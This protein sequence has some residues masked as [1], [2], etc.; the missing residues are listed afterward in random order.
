M[1]TQAKQIAKFLMAPIGVSGFSTAGGPSD[2]VTAAITSAL[3]AAA[4]NGG[5]VPLVAGSGAYGSQV[6]GVI[7]AAGLNLT[8]IYS[9]G[10]KLKYLDG[11]GSEVYGKF[12]VSGS[13]W[14]LSYFSLVGGA[15]TAF[16]MPASAMLAYEVPYLFNFDHLP[17]TALMAIVERHVA[18]AVA[19]TGA[20]TRLFAEAVAVTSANTLAALTNTATGVLQ[21]LNVNGLIYTNLGSAPP[22]SIAGKTVTWSAANA[23]F[24]LAPSDSVSAEYSY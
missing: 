10:T 7:T 24:A 23:G 1:L 4:D 8:P 9:S 21:K 22:F 5:S 14:T 17:Y 18:T 16:A 3:N 20:G 12:S 19:L 15:E 6:E 2:T 13:T 11:N